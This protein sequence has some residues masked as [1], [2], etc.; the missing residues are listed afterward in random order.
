MS[1]VVPA[2]EQEIILKKLNGLPP[3]YLLDKLTQDQKDHWH[4]VKHIFETTRTV[5]KAFFSGTPS[6]LQELPNDEKEIY[7]SLTDF[8]ISLYAVIQLGWK[9]ILDAFAQWGNKYHG[10]EFPFKSP[11]ATLAAILERDAAAQ[12]LQCKQGRFDFRPRKLY[13]LHLQKKKK[14]KGKLSLQA[15]ERYE[16]E[17]EALAK[18]LDSFRGLEI[19]CVEACHL[20][21]EKRKDKILSTKLKD[22]MERNNNLSDT[23]NRYYREMNGCAWQGGEKLATVKEG[24]TYKSVS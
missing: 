3:D 15:V 7:G 11:G 18:P 9:D 21:A 6:P 13:G 19:F 20:G 5:L 16:K 10:E 22:L 4:K 8:Y 14:A 12:F 23:L 2:E 24:G 17:A 1:A